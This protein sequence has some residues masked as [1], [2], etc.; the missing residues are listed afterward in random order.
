MAD[1]SHMPD[2]YDRMLGALDGLPDVLQTKASTIRVVQPLGV[3]GSATY[4]VQTFRQQARDD[5]GRVTAS[6]DT[7]FLETVDGTQALRLVLPPAVADVIARQ[8]DALTDRSRSKAAKT[9]AAERK[10]RGEVP[11]FARQRDAS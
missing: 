10:K 5:Q 11:G 1:T 8:R 9:Q 6:R 7:V 4:I 2:K 3:G